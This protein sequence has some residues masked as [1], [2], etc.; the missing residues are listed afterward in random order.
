MTDFAVIFDMDGVITANNNMHEL[1][2]EV[3]CDRHGLPRFSHDEFQI[4]VVGKTNEEIVSWFWPDI[5]DERARELSEEKEALY[6]DLYRPHFKLTDGLLPFLTQL[7]EAGVKVALATNAPETNMRFTLDEGQL[8][9]Y[10][11]ET[12]WAHLVPLPKP[13]PDLYLLAASKIGMDPTRCVVFEDSYT[14]IKAARAAGA[15]VIGVASTYPAE[16]LALKADK[17]ITDFRGLTVADVA[18]V[19]NA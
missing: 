15:R 11:H 12:V 4:R 18:A 10:F 1:A 5:S 16:E 2:W 6:R 3:F 17:V 19:V 7:A 9:T 13:A 14:G 8:G